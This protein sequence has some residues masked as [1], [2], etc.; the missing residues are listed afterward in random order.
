MRPFLHNILALLPVLPALAGEPPAT[1]SAPAASVP[2][3]SEWEI[4]TALYGWAQSLDGDVGIGPVDTPVDIPFKDILEDLDIAFMAAIE[5]TPPSPTGGESRWSVLADLNYAEISDTVSPLGLGPGIDFEQKQ[6][7]GNF[8][9]VFQVWET[10]QAD[11]DLFAGARVNWIEASLG[12]GRFGRS[13]D[14][15]W[16]DPLLGARFQADLGQDFFFRALGDIGGF[17]VSSDITWQG[18]AGF[19]YRVMDHGAILAGYRAIGTDY[20][21]GGFRYDVVSHGPVLGFEYRF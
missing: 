19:G 5:I 17:G 11:L 12:I 3:A 7:L 2:G 9:A 21:D 20:S 15:S 16:V 1:S 18:L 14:K 10:P 4:R 13:A 8:L 6:F